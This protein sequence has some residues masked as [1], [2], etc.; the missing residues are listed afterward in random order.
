M[1]RERDGGMSEFSVG[2]LIERVAGTAPVELHGVVLDWLIGQVGCDSAIFV[3][4]LD[5]KLRPVERNKG[6]F[7]HLH[8]LYARDPKRYQPGLQRGH[9][10]LG[11]DRLYVDLDVYS[12]RERSELPFYADIVRPQ[13]ISSQLVIAVDFHGCR[14][15]TIHLCRHGAALRFG[16]SL[17]DRLRAIVP[18]LGLIDAASST[19][20]PPAVQGDPGL[21]PR[22]LEVARL[23]GRGLE[24]KEIAALLGTRPATVRNQLHAIFRKLDV[25]NRAELAFVLAGDPC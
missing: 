15:A 25:S 12:S 22:E 10:A 6:A 2:E 11:R 16:S 8:G 21:G 17:V 3:P 18:A 7:L 9:A 23:A 19:R 5:R 13:R 20:S 1:S 24:T 4:A 14:R